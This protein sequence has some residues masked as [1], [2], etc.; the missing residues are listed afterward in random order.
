MRGS[1]KKLAIDLRAINNKQKKKQKQ[2]EKESKKN[3]KKSSKDDSAPNALRVS[4]CAVPLSAAL[5]IFNASTCLPLNKEKAY[6][7]KRIGEKN[8]QVR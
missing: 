8:A 5:N 4:A 7:E 6:R 3:E 1:S 2:K